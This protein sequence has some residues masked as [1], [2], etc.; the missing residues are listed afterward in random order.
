MQWRDRIIGRKFHSYRTT[1]TLIKYRNLHISI[2]SLD[3]LIYKNFLGKWFH[4]VKFFLT[5]L[6]IF[7]FC[8]WSFLSLIIRAAAKAIFK[9]L[10]TSQDKT[11]SS[12]HFIFKTIFWVNHKNCNMKTPF[13]SIFNSMICWDVINNSLCQNKIYVGNSIWFFDSRI[14]FY[15]LRLIILAK[16]YNCLSDL[17]LL[18]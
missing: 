8:S 10:S 16:V 13:C 17:G 14:T 6:R 3:Y 7:C 11:F 2:S 1:E 15:I 12:K 18:M 4:E 5:C 9:S